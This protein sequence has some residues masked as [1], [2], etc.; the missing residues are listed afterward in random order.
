M[1]KNIIFIITTICIFAVL[2]G[3][4][5]LKEKEKKDVPGQQIEEPAVRK[6]VEVKGYKG[7][8]I[9][10]YAAEKNFYSYGEEMS[11]GS[12]KVKVETVDL[13]DKLEDPDDSNKE[14]IESLDLSQYET[15]ELAFIEE[16]RYL[17][18]T[19]EIT[20]ES[21]SKQELVFANFEF[22]NRR[23][24]NAIGGGSGCFEW[25]EPIDE[26]NSNKVT[27]NGFGEKQW[28][29]EPKETIN[30][31]AIAVVLPAD[32]YDLYL[33]IHSYEEADYEGH[34]SLDIQL[35]ETDG[36]IFVDD[37]I[38]DKQQRD[39]KK[40]K[41]NIEYTNYT[42]FKEQENGYSCSDENLYDLTKTVGWPHN[43]DGEIQPGIQTQVQDVRIYSKQEKLPEQFQEKSYIEGMTELYT[44]ELKYDKKDFRYLYVKVKMKQLT[45][46][47]ES[48]E[49]KI[50]SQLWIYNR[51]EEGK[52]WRLG[53]PDDYY[54]ILSTNKEQLLGG[55]PLLYMKQDEE[56]VVE[57]VYVIPPDSLYNVYLFAREGAI[58]D[59]Y[60]EEANAKQYDG[61][62]SLGITNYEKGGVK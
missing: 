55:S 46:M 43:I 50:P 17:Y 42:L 36:F 45:N 35:H 14:L 34:S 56:I 58:Y 3:V 27:L 47:Y 5:F 33:C 53:Y 9:V 7:E 22:E 28:S 8:D 40:L 16:L 18:V 31:K 23:E 60:Y 41:T 1:K 15:L 52:L 48:V 59:D 29:F 24:D 54:T 32:V 11:V 38:S 26:A 10:T 20:N 39:L 2:I 19:L 51:D 25:Q 37:E 21:D 44:K 6:N 49:V 62:I 13:K 57:A 12:Y 61:G 30:I 4:N